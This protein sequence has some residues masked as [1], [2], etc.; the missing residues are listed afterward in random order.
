MMILGSPS[1]IFL[2][3]I[4]FK[5]IYPIKMGIEL[6]TIVEIIPSVVSIDLST[7]IEAAMEPM[8]IPTI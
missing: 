2:K 1:K 4:F 3:V 8:V 7:A 6:H 5:V